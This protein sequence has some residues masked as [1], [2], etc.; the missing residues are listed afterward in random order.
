[1]ARARVLRRKLAGRLF[2][3]LARRALRLGVYDTQCGFKMFDRRAGQRLF[4]L[5]KETGYLF[6]LELLALAARL[7]YRTAEVPINWADQ[8][9][10]KVKLLR[11]GLKMVRDLWRLRR[12]LP[13][14]EADRDPG[15]RAA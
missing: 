14:W 4:R 13:P 1:V 5:G 10:S 12:R 8:P 9:G 6:D 15:L 2:A 7:G 11:D 3:G